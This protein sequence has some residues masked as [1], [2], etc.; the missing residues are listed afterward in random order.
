MS[1]FYIVKLFV[2]NFYISTVICFTLEASFDNLFYSINA[3]YSSYSII[4]FNFSFYV[5]C[6]CS[7]SYNFSSYSLSTCNWYSDFIV[8][9]YEWIFSILLL[10]YPRIFS[11]AFW[12]FRI[13]SSS[14][15]FKLFSYL[16]KC[17]FSTYKT[18][19]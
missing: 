9:T 16:N 10:I 1:L 4:R 6:L 2:S 12:Y 17:F 3:F 13:F 7:Y 15:S 11:S 14:K 8:Y 19:F 18:P 5:I